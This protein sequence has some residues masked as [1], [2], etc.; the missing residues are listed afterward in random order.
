MLGVVLENLYRYPLLRNLIIKVLTRISCHEGDNNVLRRIFQRY[1]D[2][3]IGEYTYGGCFDATRVPPGT[4][5]GRFSSFA[6]EFMVI[7]SNHPTGLVTTHPFLFKPSFGL[8]KNDPR[9]LMPLSIGHDV[10]VGY[11]VT[12]LPGVS[13]IGNGS[14]IAAGSVVTRDVPP[15]SVVAGVP[16]RIIKFRFSKEEI[17]ALEKIAWWDWPIDLILSRWGDFLNLR[18]FILKYG[19]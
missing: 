3:Q 7:R 2:L 19:K 6:S 8:V 5:I 11:R 13:V 9:K 18:E 15:Y 16:A 14:I 17:S 12:I 10:W 1:H 4:R